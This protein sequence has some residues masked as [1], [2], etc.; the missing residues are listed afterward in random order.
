M[1]NARTIGL[2]FIFSLPKSTTCESQKSLRIR[3]RT[4]QTVS[5]LRV[6]PG[7]GQG[8]LTSLNPNFKHRIARVDRNKPSSNDC[9]AIPREASLPAKLAYI[10]SRTDVSQTIRYEWRSHTWS[11][12]VASS[13]DV[14]DDA[15]NGEEYSLAV[16]SVEW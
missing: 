11:I 6:Y 5:S 16:H 7:V 10:P 15:V 12:K 14:K 1:D 13:A 9:L 4:S 8:P 3:T 2:P